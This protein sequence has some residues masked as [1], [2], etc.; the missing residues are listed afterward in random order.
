MTN[1]LSR[2]AQR[3]LVARWRSAFSRRPHRR[4]RNRRFRFSSCRCPHRKRWLT[5]RRRLR[6]RSHCRARMTQHRGAAV[7]LQAPDRRLRWPRSAGH[8]RR[9][10]GS[11][12]SLSGDGRWPR[13]ALRHRRRPRRLHMVRRAVDHAQGG[14]AELDAA[15]RHAE[16]PALSAALHGGRSGQS[17][18]RARDVSR[19]HGLSHSRHQRSLDDR[20]ARLVGLHPPDQQ[21]CRRPLQPRRSA[22]KSS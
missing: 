4:R 8:D 22:P 11:H 5:R 16:A 7:A 18:R 13:D 10:Y 2:D 17:A 20:P 12:L 3:S 21:R 6:R 14:M 15:G 9:R 19:R 1:I